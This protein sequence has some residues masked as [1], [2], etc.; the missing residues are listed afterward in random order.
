MEANAR[1][2]AAIGVLVGVAVIVGVGLFLF[3]ACQEQ[4]DMQT[5]IE[6]TWNSAPITTRSTWCGWVRDGNTESAVR[7][8]AGL[9]KSTDGYEVY[10]LEARAFLRDECL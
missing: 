5:K 3:S 4:S 2:R 6:D 8:L 7:A 1:K 10:D 9:A